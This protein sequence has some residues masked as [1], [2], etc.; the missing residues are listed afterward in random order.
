MAASLVRE[1]C[2]AGHTNRIGSWVTFATCIS[3]TLEWK[4]LRLRKELKLGQIVLSRAQTTPA[5]FGANLLSWTPRHLKSLFSLADDNCK[6]RDKKK[7]LSLINPV[8]LRAERYSD[9]SRYRWRYRIQSDFS[10]GIARWNALPAHQ[11][12]SFGFYTRVLG[13][14]GRES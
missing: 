14:G 7:S 13:R 11:R 8:T 4:E 5:A 9:I 10:W 2:H 3:Q 1:R 12:S 6:L